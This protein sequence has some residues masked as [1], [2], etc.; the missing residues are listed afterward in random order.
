MKTIY[1]Y[2]IQI[3][4]RQTLLIPEGAIVRYLGLDPN[5][6][7]CLWAEVDKEVESVE[8][9]IA[10]VGTG[11]PVPPKGRH[12]GSAVQGSFVWHVYDVTTTVG[13]KDLLSPF[14]SDQT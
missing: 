11:R 2:P 1:K 7:L 9:S 3:V 4:D 12:L 6:A 13:I 14:S 10:V 8:I 5:G